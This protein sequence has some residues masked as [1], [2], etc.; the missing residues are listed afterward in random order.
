MSIENP[1][2]EPAGSELG[3]FW[4]EAGEDWSKYLALIAERF[5]G[6]LVITCA[7]IY[8]VNSVESMKRQL[9]FVHAQINVLHLIDRL[10]LMHGVS[11][12]VIDV[13]F[14]KG[15]DSSGEFGKE[16][17]RGERVVFIRDGYPVL[18]PQ[19]QTNPEPEGQ[20]IHPPGYHTG[21]PGPY[22]PPQFR[23]GGR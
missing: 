10:R 8:Y 13:G 6:N 12:D 5:M 11:R 21:G 20:E 15:I 1:M 7:N 22:M 4:K 9:N 16:T 3:K 23:V 2:Q 17:E 19:F 14:I 18:S